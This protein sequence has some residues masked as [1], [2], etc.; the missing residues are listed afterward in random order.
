VGRRAGIT[1]DQLR[2]LAAF[3]TSPHFDEAERLVLQLAVQ[4]TQTP[5]KVPDELYAALRVRF[6]EAAL[7][8]LNAAICWEN[9][10][11]RFNRTFEIEPEGFS[12]G[13]YCPLPEMSALDQRVL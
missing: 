9:Y 1:E 8:E 3:E 6:S 10:R 12:E 4:L 5:A 11:A 7:V 13:Q 2:D